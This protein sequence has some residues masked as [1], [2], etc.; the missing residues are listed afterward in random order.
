MNYSIIHILCIEKKI[1]YLRLHTSPLY[2]PLF[3][4][5]KKESLHSKRIFNREGSWKNE[6]GNKNYNITRN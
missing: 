1:D 4:L 6:L 3:L 5:N 2:I